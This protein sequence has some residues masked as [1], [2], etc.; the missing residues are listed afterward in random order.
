[1][2]DR[3]HDLDAE[4][5]NQ[6]EEFYTALSDATE[7][8]RDGHYADLDASHMLYLFEF[9]K[10]VKIGG[11]NNPFTCIE[12]P[13]IQIPQAILSLL[14]EKGLRFT[15]YDNKRIVEEHTLH[16]Y[17]R[18]PAGRGLDFNDYPD[19]KP[20]FVKYAVELR[21]LNPVVDTKNSPLP[22]LEDLSEVVEALRST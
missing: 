4:H 10:I 22:P 14:D 5:V 6:P 15:F 3:V 18:N 17:E 9:Y 12:W 13:G 21:C 16:F 11:T 19:D 8:T 20:D 1:M 7:A 2:Y